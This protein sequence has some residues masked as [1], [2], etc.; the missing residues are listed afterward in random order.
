MCLYINRFICG[1]GRCIGV[2]FQVCYCMV[3]GSLCLLNGPYVVWKGLFFMR[4]C[5]YMYQDLTDPGT[6]LYL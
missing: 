5:V 2:V 6:I 1:I 3:F 4:A